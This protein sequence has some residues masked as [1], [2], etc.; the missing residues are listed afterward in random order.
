MQ[1]DVSLSDKYDLSKK[2]VLLRGIKTL[3]RMMWMQATG[4]K[5]EGINT[6]LLY[7]LAGA[8]A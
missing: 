1:H 8:D 4:D 2:Q 6:C 5:A 3:V 7:P